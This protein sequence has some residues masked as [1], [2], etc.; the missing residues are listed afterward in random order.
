MVVST[1]RY[2]H[3]LPSIDRTTIACGPDEIGALGT[4]AP[5]GDPEPIQRP[6]AGVGPLQRRSYRVR[7]QGSPLGPGELLELVAAHLNSA[8]PVEVAS[9][10]KTKGEA[11]HLAVGDEYVVHMPGP[12]EGP[13]RVVDRA[14]TSFRL[15]TLRGHMEAGEISFHASGDGDDLMFEIVSV[16]RSGDLLFHMLHDRLGVAREM[17]AHMWIHVCER[18]ARL[19]GG[20]RVGRYEVETRTPRERA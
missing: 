9:F 18:V 3:R 8:S 4:E 19:S 17:Q 1:L 6:S 5:P 15:A 11:G 16:A 20:S 14:A 12:W 13:V 7:I 2:L 10:E